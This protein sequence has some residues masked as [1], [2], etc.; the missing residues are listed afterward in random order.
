[1]GGSSQP[2]VKVVIWGNVYVRD[3]AASLEPGVDFVDV[4]AS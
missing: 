4:R 3:K 2:H 1:M